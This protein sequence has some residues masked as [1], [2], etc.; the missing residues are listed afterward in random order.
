M[1]AGLTFLVIDDPSVPD[2]TL[3]AGGVMGET[4]R[5][6]VSIPFLLSLGLFDLLDLALTLCHLCLRGPL[7]FL[8][9]RNRAFLVGR[10]AFRVGQGAGA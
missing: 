7:N 2:T 9:G 5:S 8:L 6:T 1:P 3:P 10:R 4:I